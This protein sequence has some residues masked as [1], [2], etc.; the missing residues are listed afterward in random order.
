MVQAVL[1][2]LQHHVKLNPLANPLHDL[3]GR[4]IFIFLFLY[5]PNPPISSFFD[6]KEP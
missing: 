6:P 4:V 5:P 1:V 3:R 2:V